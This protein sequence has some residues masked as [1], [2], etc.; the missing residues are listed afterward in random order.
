MK[1]AE[2][3]LCDDTMAV[4]NSMTAQHRRDVRAVWN[5][6]PKTG[7]WTSV[8][9]VPD[10]LAEDVSKMVWFAKT[11]SACSATVVFGT[12]D[13]GHFVSRLTFNERLLRT[14]SVDAIGETSGVRWWVRGYR[15]HARGR[16]ALRGLPSVA[17]MKTADFRNR[18][19]W[20]SGRG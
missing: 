9:E 13:G 17:V 3:R 19:D 16:S 2:D 1:P 15:C 11:G 14:T 8:M 20:S 10:P 7:V 18:D 4:W 5:A 6:R 12:G